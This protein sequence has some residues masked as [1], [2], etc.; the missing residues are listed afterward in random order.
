MS[1]KISDLT[2]GITPD[3]TEPVAAVQ[4]SATIK[5]TTQQIANLAPVTSVASKTGVVTLAKSDVGLSNVDNTS[6]ANKPVSTAQQTALDLKEATANKGVASGYASLNSSVEVVEKSAE[7]KA[8]RLADKHDPKVYVPMRSA[9][10]ELAL[11]GAQFVLRASTAT[12]RDATTG[13]VTSAAINELRRERGANGEIQ[14]KLEGAGTNLFLYSEDFTNAAWAKS[15][16]TPTANDTTAPDGNVTADL[17]LET[18]VTAQHLFYQNATVSSGK[19]ACSID[20]KGKSRTWI[21]IE[22]AGGSSKAVWYNLSGAG[23]I[24]TE[25]VGSVGKITLLENGFYRCEFERAE[26]GAQQMVVRVTTGDG[27]I[28]DYLGDVT[29]GVWVWGAQIED[30]PFVSSYIPTTTTSITRAADDNR[31]DTSGNVAGYSQPRA[32]ILDFDYDGIVGGFDTILQGPTIF[33]QFLFGGSSDRFRAQVSVD[34]GHFIDLSSPSAEFT[35]KTAYRVGISFD[36]TTLKLWVNG[37]NTASSSTQGTTT[38]TDKNKI[39]LMNS[40]TSR[41]TYGHMGRLLRYDR[42]P[43]DAEMAILTTP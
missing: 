6:D 12:Y 21:S 35:P 22:P 24:G 23:A 33:D 29:K 18:A 13:L 4:S 9:D 41:P 36:G 25:S 37:T 8:W 34:S 40:S 7:F 32:I 11:S 38:I 28:A 20:L 5:L 3:G 15:N 31:I 39:Y 17:L 42:C 2:A 19:I 14:V 10:D 30:A 43:S 26:T 1:V 16:L 27:V